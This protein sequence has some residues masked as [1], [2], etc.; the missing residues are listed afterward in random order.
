MKLIHDDNFQT[1]EKKKKILRRSTEAIFFLD[2][3]EIH[4]I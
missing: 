4:R 3:R 1:S 2:I